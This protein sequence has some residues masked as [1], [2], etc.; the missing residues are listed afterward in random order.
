MAAAPLPLAVSVVLSLTR[1][2]DIPMTITDTVLVFAGAPLAAAGL[3]GLLIFGTSA[4][5]APRYRPGRPFTFAPVWFVSAPRP[6]GA[7]ADQLAIPGPDRAAL[8]ADTAT[9]TVNIRPATKKGGAR[10]TW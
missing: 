9:D 7:H 1:A 4:R 8:Q 6:G 10:G 2:V 3:I 5:R